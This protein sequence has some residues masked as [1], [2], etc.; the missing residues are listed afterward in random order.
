MRV[1]ASAALPAA[2]AYD[3]EGSPTMSK[4]SGVVE[5]D[6]TVIDDDTSDDDDDD[7]TSDDDDDGGD[8]IKANNWGNAEGGDH[9]NETIVG[10]RYG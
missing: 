8:K 5:V 3:I 10:Q 6:T 7:D 9:L 2:A 1:S 4:V